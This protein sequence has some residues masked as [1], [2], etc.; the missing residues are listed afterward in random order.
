MFNDIEIHINS[1]FDP[2]ERITHDSV[3]VVMAKTLNE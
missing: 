1:D 2:G 3:Q